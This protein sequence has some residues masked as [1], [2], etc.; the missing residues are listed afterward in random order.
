MKEKGNLLR[1]PDSQQKKE[2]LFSFFVFIMKAKEGNE[3]IVFLSSS[4]CVPDADRAILN[5]ANGF[6][7]RLWDV[8]PPAPKC[9][10][11][12][13][14]PDSPE[15]TDRFAGDMAQAF[16]EAD[17]EFG[18]LA[19]LDGRNPVDA[20]ALVAWSD[21]IILAGGHVPT[22]NRF[23]QQIRL[24]ELLRDYPG[25]ILGISAGTMN[26]AAMVYAQPELEGESDDPDY[27]RFLPGLGL[28]YVNVLPHYQK[29]KDE[30]LDGKRLF[31]D[32]TYADSF[33]H[34]FLALVDGSYLCSRDGET[35]LLGEAYRLEDGVLWQI[36]REGDRIRL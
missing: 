11:V 7:D 24:A 34:T 31:E 2:L 36:S 13:S 26:S 1:L 33:G 9:L 5:P 21:L 20:G 25:V 30:I 3:M 12:C 10:F 32:I 22:Q 28:T 17:M 23:F 6:V 29:V 4:P 18:D 35:E 27:A 8:V 19:V 15:L 16:A 14:D